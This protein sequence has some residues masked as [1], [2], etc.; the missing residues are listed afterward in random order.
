MHEIEEVIFFE[1]GQSEDMFQTKLFPLLRLDFGICSLN[2]LSHWTWNVALSFFNG[3]SM[4]F[5]IDVQRYPLHFLGLLNWILN[6]SE[7]TIAQITEDCLNIT[8]LYLYKG[9][10]KSNNLDVILLLSSPKI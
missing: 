9:L 10:K 5:S 4:D 2:S 1:F 7:Y 8:V 6:I 3:N